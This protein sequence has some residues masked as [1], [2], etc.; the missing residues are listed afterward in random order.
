MNICTFANEEIR[1]KELKITR[2][3][4]FFSTQK[5][6]ASMK[7]SRER[8]ALRRR[9]HNTVENKCLSNENPIMSLPLNVKGT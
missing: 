1:L 9:S 6:R 3:Y 8:K 2:F 7:N 4:S 5:K